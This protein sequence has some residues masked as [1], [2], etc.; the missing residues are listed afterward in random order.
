MQPPNWRAPPEAGYMDAQGMRRESEEPWR[1]VSVQRLLACGRTGVVSTM[2]SGT[3]IVSWNQLVKM[4]C[5]QQVAACR[6]GLTAH[7]CS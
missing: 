2:L 5:A 6:G 7:W 1:P 3:C 4:Q